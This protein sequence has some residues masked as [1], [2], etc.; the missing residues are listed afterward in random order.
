MIVVRCADDIAASFE[1]EADARHFWDALLI[2]PE[3][4][5]VDLREGKT[6]QSEFGR[7]APARR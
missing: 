2:W 5:A 1:H 7:I 6:H 4:F 3:H